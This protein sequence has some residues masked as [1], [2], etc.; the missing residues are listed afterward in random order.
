MNCRA[1]C[2]GC[3]RPQTRFGPAV[4]LA[5]GDAHPLALSVKNKKMN[6]SRSNAA[7]QRNFGGTWDV[8]ARLNTAAQGRKMTRDGLPLGVAVR[9][10]CLLAAV[11]PARFGN[12][13]TG[14]Q[15]EL[16]YATTAARSRLR[17]I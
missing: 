9:A 13:R 1:Q 6:R 7:L 10:D 2:R 11:S 12:P 16:G 14:L 5:V 17:S 4:A 15:Y 8:A 3:R